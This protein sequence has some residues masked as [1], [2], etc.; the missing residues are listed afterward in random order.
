MKNTECY[1]AI[2]RTMMYGVSSQR[3][4]DKYLSSIFKRSSSVDSEASPAKG[5]FKGGF[6]VD[7]AEIYSSRIKGM[8]CVR[9]YYCYR[10]FKC[11]GDGEDLLP[12]VRN[13]KLTIVMT[14]LWST[15]AVITIRSFE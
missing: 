1:T 9:R 13:M 8:G 7:I 5:K 11:V 14:L 4:G 6:I 3:S 15:I 10:I 12:L 2:R